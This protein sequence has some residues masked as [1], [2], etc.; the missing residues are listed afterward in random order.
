MKDAAIHLES[1]LDEETLETIAEFI[2]GDDAKR[3]PIYRSSMYLTRFF[4][5]CNIQER[6]GGETRK[7]WVLS[8]LSNLEPHQ[9]E[10]VIL[11]L[12]DPKTYRAN[13]DQIRMAVSSMNVI[14][15]LE[16]LAIAF[17]GA[18]P[19]LCQGVV[20]SFEDKDFSSPVTVTQDESDFLS[21]QFPEQVSLDQLDIDE[22]LSKI[23]QDRLS[24][25]KACPK[26]AAPLAIIILLGSTL[27]GLLLAI[28]RQ[29]PVAFNQSESAPRD[30][31]GKVLPF[32]SW[33]LSELIDTG[34]D[35][36]LLNLDVKKF[37]HS[38]RDFRNFIHP[39]EQLARSFSPN[40]HTA[41]ICWQVFRAALHQICI[42]IRNVRES[43]EPD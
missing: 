3:F 32:R 27:E 25:I 5:S 17:D 10:K 16:G 1:A 7:W 15:S 30:K 22:N 24:E 28:A 36:G 14:L 33:K 11:K 19:Y 18:R 43:N 13:V 4:E 26:E 21:I 6:H 39:H 40:Q 9:M 12:V 20:M 41:E 38:L 2:V 29:C 37:S 31:D 8:V 35:I 23:L 42:N 34:F